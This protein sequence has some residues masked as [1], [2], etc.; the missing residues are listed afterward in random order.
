MLK[1]TFNYL[2]KHSRQAEP[3]RK[4]NINKKKKTLRGLRCIVYMHM[5]AAI[6]LESMIS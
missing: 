3:E 5:D 2:D 1:L 6:E 4:L